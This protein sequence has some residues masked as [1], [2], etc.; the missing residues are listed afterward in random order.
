[1]Y[2][3]PEERREDMIKRK[4]RSVRWVSYTCGCK[5]LGVVT[6]PQECGTHKKGI[7]MTGPMFPHG[8]PC[9]MDPRYAC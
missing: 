4:I 9:L 2:R 5:L 7:W 3:Y 8:E 6:F 1:M